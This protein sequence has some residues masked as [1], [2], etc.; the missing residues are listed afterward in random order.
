MKAIVT[1]YPKCHARE[2]DAQIE[3]A[4][5]KHQDRWEIVRTETGWYVVV[6]TTE[7]K[8]F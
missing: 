4:N 2:F 8:S 7:V 3:L 6:R 5:K 1:K